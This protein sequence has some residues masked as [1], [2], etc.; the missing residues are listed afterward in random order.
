MGGQITAP[1]QRERIIEE[2]LTLVTTKG[3]AWVSSTVKP[4]RFSAV[5]NE[6]QKTA[7]D[8]DGDR[9]HP[10]TEIRADL[11]KGTNGKLAT[12][13]R[14]MIRHFFGRRP[15]DL[16]EPFVLDVHPNFPRPIVAQDHAMY[17]EC[18][19]D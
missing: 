9:L 12:A 11:G 7:T 2:H 13:S 15:L 6:E 5:V 14:E 4:V 16:D 1:G 17:G 3:A 19:Q 10:R 8:Q 18:V